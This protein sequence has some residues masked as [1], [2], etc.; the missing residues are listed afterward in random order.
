MKKLWLLA[1]WIAG[2][3]F[4][5]CAAGGPG[6]VKL[7]LWDQLSFAIPNNTQ[8]I[9]GV[10]LGIGSYTRN[11]TGVQWDV[12]WAETNYLS[13]ISLAGGIS[14]TDQAEGVQWAFVTMS[15]NMTGAQL[16]LVNMTISMTGA[17]VGG[18]NMS[19]H[20]LEGAQV[21]FYNQAEYIH[22]VQFGLVNYAR[23]INGLQIGFINIAENGYLPAMVFVN[24]RF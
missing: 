22:G 13:G 19:T 2:F 1:V 15:A 24:G 23:Y 17:Q 4:P 9:E 3:A 18:V 21:G 12:I 20:A 8:E 14:K 16:G 6:Y 10:D 7:S 11:M 5:A